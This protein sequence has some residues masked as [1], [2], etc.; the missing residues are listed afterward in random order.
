MPGLKASRSL[1]KSGKAEN[2]YKKGLEMLDICLLGTGGMMPLPYRWLTSLMARYNGRSILIDCGEGTQIAMKEKGWSPKPI[3]IMCFTHFHADHVSGLPGMLLTMGNAQRT[4]PLLM[5]GP[6]G[7]TRVVNAL[8]TI[9]PE[10][11]FEIQCRELTEREE[12]IPFEGFYLEAFRVNH[13]VVCY[14]YSIVV[15]RAGKFDPVKAEALGLEK[16]Y[17][18]RLQKGE[19]ITLEDR[20]YTPDMVMGEARKGIKVTYCTDTRPVD[21]IA[22][23]ARDADLFICEGMYGEAEKAQKA[24]E[25]KHMTFYEAAGLAQKAGAAQLW[26]THYS[27]SLTRPE[28]YMDKVRE[29]FPGAVA[30]RDGMTAQLNFE[31]E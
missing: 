23:H 5:I 30:A 21:T 11:P 3:D 13:N 4:E 25:Y 10:L 28:E 16:R 7:L 22:E 31:E 2:F 15:S 18:G 24:K 8:R 26:L 9:A 6:K 14:G 20:V 12:I 19:I 29:I 17:W 27:P 1:W